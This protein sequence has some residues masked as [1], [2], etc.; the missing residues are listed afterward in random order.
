MPKYKYEHPDEIGLGQHHAPERDLKTVPAQPVGIP[1]VE[2]LSFLDLTEEQQDKLAGMHART[3]HD[4][5]LHHGMIVTVAENDDPESP[6]NG[7]PI[8]ADA[9]GNVV[10]EWTD[11]HGDSRR[12]T[13]TSE[14]FEQFFTEVTA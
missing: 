1:P 14:A 10:V 12:T 8:M 6:D 3:M 7:K 9:D 2:Q 4:L 13:I 11:L 5:D